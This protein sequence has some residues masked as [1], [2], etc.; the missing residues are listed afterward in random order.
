MSSSLFPVCTN[1]ELE[2]PQL[3][4]PLSHVPSCLSVG[5]LAGLSHIPKPSHVSP[6][7][8]PQLPLWSKLPPAHAWITLTNVSASAFALPVLSQSSGQSHLFKTEIRQCH[9]FVCYFL[10]A[11]SAFGIRP[12]AFAMSVDSSEGTCVFSDLILLP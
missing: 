6:S 11:P 8:P 12:R 4:L 5:P 2:S 9:P 10:V 7:P 1:P 3:P